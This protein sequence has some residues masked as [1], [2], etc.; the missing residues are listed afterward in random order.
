MEKKNIYVFDFDGTFYK[1][2]TSDIPKLEDAIDLA[3]FRLFMDKLEN[4]PNK[5]EVLGNLDKKF[6]KLD[7]TSI[8]PNLHNNNAEK[9]G[10]V[11]SYFDGKDLKFSDYIKKEN[12]NKTNVI[13]ARAL[14]KMTEPNGQGNHR[15][16]GMLNL[17]LE[18]SQK[19]IEDYYKKYATITYRNIEKNTHIQKILDKAFETD[20]LVCV[21]TDN[22][23]DNVLSGMRSLGYDP[24]KFPLIV[25]MFDCESGTTKKM[26]KGV[27][28]FKVILKNF[29]DEQ[30]VE[31]DLDKVKFYD[32]NKNICK[33]MQSLGIKSF[34][35]SSNAVSPIE[36]DTDV[37]SALLNNAGR[38]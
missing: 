24:A 25:D 15:V 20:S 35:V 37:F 3:M 16:S 22:S 31:Y 12:G 13:L 26:E 27:N 33:N 30:G 32:D 18:I 19:D 36:L 5:D 7:K 4:S 34:A 38:V 28:A 1:T 8:T 29:C 6:K 11:V 14:S 23:K 21:Y 2:P 9:V 10:P 17:G